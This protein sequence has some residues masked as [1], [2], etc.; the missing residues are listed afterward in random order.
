MYRRAI[1]AAC[2]LLL[3]VATAA[4]AWACGGLLAPNGSVNL[5]RTSTLAAYHQGVE[6]YVTS[7]E[8]AGGGGKFGSIIPLPGVPTKVQ[9]GGDWTLQRLGLETQPPTR[10]LAFVEA[11]AL[12]D[13]KVLMEKRIDALDVTILQGGGVAVGKWA[14]ANGFDLPPDAPEV[15]DFYAARSPIFLAAR[16]DVDRAKKRGFSVG[17]GTPVHL[18]IPTSNPWVP[19]R[20]L[21]LGKQASEAI[22]ADVYLLTDREPSMLPVPRPA[23]GLDLE[24]SEPA[25][26]SLITDLRSDRGMRWIPESGMWLSYL[27]IDALAGDLT[28]DLAVDV[29]SAARP[30][31]VDAGLVAPPATSTPAAPG[32]WWAWLMAAA[33]VAGVV[34][35]TGRMVTGGR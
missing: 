14:E 10:R 19:L 28:H 21:A 30:S 8:F 3:L 34:G 17:D 35:L 6:H 4:P 23:P 25:S 7:F 5:L 20:I 2:S 27:R 13:A 1:V 16:F 29:S 15:L 9:K 11:A 26:Q 31:W 12:N 18:T 24:V 33:L 22:E 32:T